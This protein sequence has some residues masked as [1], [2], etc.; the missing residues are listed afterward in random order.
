MLPDLVFVSTGRGENDARE[1]EP[2]DE[3]C[4][5]LIEDVTQSYLEQVRTLTETVRQMDS[6]L[7]RRS[8]LREGNTAGVFNN[9][10]L[11]SGTSASGTLTDSQKISLQILLDV[12]AYMD[13][14]HSV[15]VKDPMAMVPSFNILYQETHGP[16][17]K[18]QT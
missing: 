5:S 7:Q 9:A 16:R 8:K 17:N 6:A 14:L 11:P 15:G 1:Q 2:E 10:L 13:E 18:S 4:L 12:S 3:W